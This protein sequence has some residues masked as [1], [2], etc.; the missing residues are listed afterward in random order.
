MD[1]RQLDWPSCDDPL[2]DK[3]KR[4]AGTMASAALA[5]NA[6]TLYAMLILQMILARQAKDP[7]NN[8]NSIILITNSLAALADSIAITE[9]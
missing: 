6:I 8:L 7:I 2:F 9:L 1:S 4:L 3:A 5:S